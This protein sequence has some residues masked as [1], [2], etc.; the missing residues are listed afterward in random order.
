MSF[1]VGDTILGRYTIVE[2]L[3]A[4]G[5]G[6]VYRAQDPMLERDVALKVL[7]PHIGQDPELLQRF[8][9]EARVL[10]KIRNPSIITVHDLVTLEDQRLVLI[11][12][13]VPG[14]SLDGYI[15]AH[16]PLEW[17]QA[18]QIGA[19][20]AGALAEA[21]EAGV[22]HRDIK[23]SNIL[24]EPDGEIRV[25]DFGI[26]RISGES[27]MT[28]QGESIGTP[29]YMSPEQ[30][31]GKETGPPSDIYS[32]GAVLYTAATGQVPF[33]TE[34]GGFAAALAHI[35]R[36]VPDPRDV[37]PEVP[38]AAAEVI[39][40]AL[41]KE[42]GDRFSSA[43]EMAQAL[44]QSAGLGPGDAPMPL[45]SSPDTG[46]PPAGVVAAGV[47]Q[48]SP[49]APGDTS[50]GPVPT[51]AAQA[52]DPPP[53]VPPASGVPSDGAV[54]LAPPMPPAPPPPPP[55]GSSSLRLA[56]IAGG[57]AV[58]ALV[59]AGM[60]ALL[61]MSRDSSQDGAQTDA[62]S[63][64]TA[65]SEPVA[66]SAAP[67]TSAA[68]TAPATSPAPQ[69]PATSA[70]QAPATSAPGPESAEIDFV[71]DFSDPSPADGAF[72][73]FAND[74]SGF[75]IQD[76]VLIGTVTTPNLLA[77][78]FAPTPAVTDSEISVVG[79]IIGDP[80]QA[81]W[82]VI[83]RFVDNENFY[84]FTFETTGAASIW[85]LRA[86][87]WTVLAEALDSVPPA[88]Q[89]RMQ[90]RCAGDELSLGVDGGLVASARDSS[91]GEGR[92]AVYV[93][94]GEGTPRARAAFDSYQQFTGLG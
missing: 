25:A 49:G 7:L 22:V 11:L 87:E 79:G 35:N 84:L 18:A 72:D 61:M 55:G 50:G 39:M 70:P 58:L 9:R 13:Y 23:P 68:T 56:L 46:A 2:R 82:G 21:H 48:L 6:I 67:S 83:C 76:G 14:G 27:S 1:E 4:G 90:V 51:P 15:Q 63:S 8:R 78:S 74:E 85:R 59:V 19:A 64:P 43:L 10:A 65:S 38:D 80:R 81:Q 29:A 92:S 66:S 57:I 16:G 31:L 37:R 30:A 69:S 33:V 34:E 41:Q 42:P 20:A 45:A 17:R 47:T 24:L 60:V 44:R 94:T 77:W 89:N 75:E 32:L 26:A 73:T 86:G 93:G 52:A 54:P 53:P 12:E 36:P 88:A 3:G 62:T 91:F 40:R 71:E 28:M 5:M